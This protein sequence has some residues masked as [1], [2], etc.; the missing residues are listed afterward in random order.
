MI[1]IFFR[2]MA[3]RKIFASFLVFLFV[4]VSLPTFLAYALSRTFLEPDFYIGPVA[5]STYEFMLDTAARNI[6]QKDPIL[7][8]QFQQADIRKV[9]GETFTFDSFQ[10]IMDDLSKDIQTLKTSPGQPLTLDFKPYSKTLEDVATRL[11]IHIF[12]SL[13]QCKTDELPEFNEDGIATCVPSGVNYEV[14]SGPLAKQFEA[15]VNNALP[16]QVDLGVSKEQNGFAFVFLFTMTDQLQIYFFGALMLLIVLIAFVL[17]HPFASITRYEGLAFL[18][19]GFTGFL[20]SVGLADAPRWLVA[21][22]DASNQHLVQVLGGQAALGRFVTYVF[23][24]FC[25][26]FQKISFIFMIL[27]ALLL[28]FHFLFV[29]Q[30]RKHHG[31]FEE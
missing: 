9:I 19:S 23:S 1:R 26:E 30:D 15:S 25:G 29:R 17:Y 14:A 10:Q 4:V 3:I 22:Y 6:Y 2:I 13:P 28:L 16:D 27:G 18:L 21:S 20:M 11:A 24:F 12:Q 7:Q 8:K 31:E 5:N